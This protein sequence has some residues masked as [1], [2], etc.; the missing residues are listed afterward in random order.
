MDIVEK[1]VS[2]GSRDIFDLNEFL[3]RPLFAHLAHNAKDGSRES[4]V[5]FYWDGDSLWIIGG[6]SFPTYLKREPRCAIG[7]VDWNVATGRLHHVGMRGHAE[8]SLLTSRSPRRSSGSILARLKRNGTSVLRMSDIV[9]AG[10][11]V[12]MRRLRLEQHDA[13]S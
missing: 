8:A 11:S 9:G 7:I 4:P 12:Q 6:T 5:W 2:A 3:S 13:E 10:P 1:K